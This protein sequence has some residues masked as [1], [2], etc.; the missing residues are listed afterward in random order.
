MHVTFCSEAESSVR[1]ARAALER[2]SRDDEL[3]E[4]V[5]RTVESVGEIRKFVTAAQHVVQGAAEMLESC[6]PVKPLDPKDEMASSVEEAEDAIALLIE[7]ME[8]KRSAAFND[9]ALGGQDERRVID[10]YTNT[11]K[12]LSGLHDA[13]VRL[14]WAVMEHDADLAPTSGRTYHA[15]EIEKLVADLDS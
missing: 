12:A 7:A 8:R 9:P 5:E 4:A 10:A 1:A 14:R 13:A 3:R 15:S 11:I 2:F 6:D